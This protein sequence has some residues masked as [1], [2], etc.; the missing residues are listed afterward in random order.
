[1]GDTPHD[2]GFD[3]AAKIDFVQT[4]ALVFVPTIFA[5]GFVLYAFAAA[6]KNESF[7]GRL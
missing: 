7:Q 1:V 4:V 5:V 3:P 2:P 6:T